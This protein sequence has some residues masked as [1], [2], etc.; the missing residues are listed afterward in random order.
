MVSTKETLLFIILT[1]ALYVL[2]QSVFGGPAWTFHEERKQYYLHQFD[3]KQPD[4]NY[5]NALVVEAMKVSGAA[6][7]RS[8][9]SCFPTSGESVTVTHCE[10][11]LSRFRGVCEHRRGLEWRMGLL[12]TTRK[13][14]HLQCYRLY[15]HILRTTSLHYKFSQSAFNSHFLATDLNNR[16]SSAFVLTS[17]PAV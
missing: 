13:C 15:T 10:P 3:P 9:R 14:K 5:N 17:L 1:S 16:D 2:Q 4:L 8:E 6:S 12:A 11:L 7:F